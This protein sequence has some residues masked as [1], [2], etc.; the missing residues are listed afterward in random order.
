MPYENPYQDTRGKTETFFRDFFLYDAFTR[1][2]ADY[3][4]EAQGVAASMGGFNTGFITS[5]EDREL[6]MNIYKNQ[7]IADQMFYNQITFQANLNQ[8]ETIAEEAFYLNALQVEQARAQRL[9]AEINKLQADAAVERQ[10]DIAKM[11][12]ERTEIIARLTQARKEEDKAKA[13]KYYLRRDLAEKPSINLPPIEDPKPAYIPIIPDVIAP[14]ATQ[15]ASF[16]I[17]LGLGV[18]GA[19]VLS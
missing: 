14:D 11:R 3:A 19:L 2:S 18:L 17:L 12:A 8:R 5:Q 4:Y 1:G 10:E 9:T 13:D 16:K 15:A 6:F 7:V